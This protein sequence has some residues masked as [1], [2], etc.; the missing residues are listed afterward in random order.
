VHK[1]AA[2]EQLGGDGLHREGNRNC[3]VG[4]P[5]K[6]KVKPKRAQ[7]ENYFTSTILNY[8]L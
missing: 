8:R 3:M 6:K 2:I 5:E 1:C 4:A 7:R